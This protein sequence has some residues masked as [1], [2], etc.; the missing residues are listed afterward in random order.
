MTIHIAQFDP[1]TASDQ[2]WAAFNETR[3]AIDREFLP[4]EPILDDAETRREIQAPNPMIEFRRWLAMEGDEVGGAIRA[5]F[6]RPGTP[7][8][9]D[10][11]RFLWAGG[12]VRASSRRRGIGTRLLREVHGLMHSLDKTVLTMSA[13][14]EPGHAFIKYVGAVEKHRTVEQRAVFADLDW[15]RLRQ[16]E[17]GAAAQ[18]L[19]WERYA[20]RVPRDVL[21]DLLPVFTELFADVPLGGLETAPISSEMNGYDLW[22]ETLERVG[23]AHHL[24]LLRAPDGSVT[25]LSEAGWDIRAPR[26]LCAN[27]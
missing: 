10:H 27:S 3:R 20:G 13:Q 16:W 17:D 12:G 25:G 6:R 21:V 11:A 7:N 5:A 14:A 26:A 15:P 24:V 1:H 19:S 22:Y 4:D 18:G 8:E 2:L 9:K 23:G